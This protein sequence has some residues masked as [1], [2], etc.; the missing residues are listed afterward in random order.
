MESDRTE[1]G[2]YGPLRRF[3]HHRS[4]LEISRVRLNIATPTGKTVPA[5]RRL[6]P[7]SPAVR[8]VA[9]RAVAP[10]SA[11]AA[12]TVWALWACV[13]L[14]T[15]TISMW[16]RP[17]DPSPNVIASGLL[18]DGFLWPLRLWDYEHY[19]ALSQHWYPDGVVTGHYA[20]FPLF[21]ALLAAGGGT[22]GAA[23]IGTTVAVAASAAAFIG[24]SIANP[25][26]SVRRTAIALAC[27]PKSYVLLLAYP[28]GLALAG[29]VWAW[30]LATRG[31][32]TSAALLGVVAAT[33][34]PN[35]FLIAIPLFFLAMRARG[36][37]RWR[38]VAAPPLA[39]AGV[40]A[41]F[42]QRSGDP[43]AYTTAQETWVTGDRLD[44]LL[45]PFASRALL[46]EATLAI[47]AVVLCVIA[48]RSRL[49]RAWAAYAT[50][51]V[52]MSLASGSVDGTGRRMLLA[53]P[54]VW[55]AAS[56]RWLGRAWAFA[57]LG[58]CLAVI[59]M[60]TMVS[61]VP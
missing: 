8:D 14:G 11:W 20:F 46:W 50:A 25:L 38:A 61:H 55:V 58:I 10:D 47:L 7:R 2:A 9:A 26:A 28:D 17:Y 34:R 35:G 21:P 45:T 53:F 51:I 4:W 22:T 27:L 39:F 23:V 59:H 3:E 56:A 41:Y 42:W 52:G 24:V 37:A 16:V 54:L 44:L 57:V 19:L 36:N 48:W 18:A 6:L 13:M 5:R 30:I 60:L 1:T 33:A 40:M 32:W 31:R 12:V 43:L 15:A 49:S 29:A